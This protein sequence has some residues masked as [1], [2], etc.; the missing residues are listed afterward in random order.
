M[1][2]LTMHA[3]LANTLFAMAVLGLPGAVLSASSAL[4]AAAAATVGA[5]SP[6]ALS[7]EGRKDARRYF[8]VLTVAPV[9]VDRREAY[10]LVV[11]DAAAG[12]PAADTRPLAMFSFF[13][14]PQVG[15]PVEFTAPLPDEAL[16]TLRRDGRLGLTVALL[17]VEEGGK[18]ETSAVEIRSAQLKVE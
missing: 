10:F 1:R 5:G 17:P 4:A 6:A 8:L 7:V 9:R 18:L 15:K 16:A 3:L 13:P 14:P 2:S 11:Y 12:T